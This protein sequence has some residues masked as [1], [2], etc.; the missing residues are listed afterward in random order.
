VASTETIAE[1]SGVPG[2]RTTVAQGTLIGGRYRLIERIGSGA[3]GEVWR[4]R[5]EDLNT[6][7]AIKIA[8]V[9]DESSSKLADRFRFEAQ[10][11]AQLAKHTPHIVAVHDAGRHKGAPYMVM[12]LVRGITLA[13]LVEREGPLPLKRVASIVRQIASALTAAHDRA[14][15]HR[16]I[17]PPNILVVEDPE[18]D[19]VKVVDFGVAKAM[20][21]RLDVDAPKATQDGILV[22]TPSY[23]S[24]EQV[25]GEASAS[26][27]LWAL[28]VCAY[29]A[30]TGVDAFD[31]SSLTE[32]FGAVATATYVPPSK[33]V[34]VPPVIDAWFRRAL[35]PNAQQRF[36]S[37]DELATSF[38]RAALVATRRWPPFVVGAAACALVALTLAVIVN[39]LGSDPVAQGSE[40]SAPLP[41]AEA[42]PA[43]P[44]EASAPPRASALPSTTSAPLS[45]TTQPALPPAPSAVRPLPRPPGPTAPSAPPPAS[46]TSSPA[47]APSAKPFDP[48]ETL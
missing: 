11:S 1:T 33:H 20:A 47:P 28:A 21:A 6:E 19:M 3:M 42:S 48:S 29:E 34:E 37:A 32:I 23:M 7:V 13:A 30:L 12:E 5:H 17:K 45:R 27:D 14:I 2:A 35:A 39:K 41:L 40:M 16:D 44:V 8:T 18:G 38:E 25:A 10:V 15:W 24:P 26:G 36:A 4:A 31:G 46:A 43:P 22:G 9:V